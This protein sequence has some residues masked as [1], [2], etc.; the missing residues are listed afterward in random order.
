MSRLVL[1]LSLPA[2]SSTAAP[3]A[4][5]TTPP[6]DAAR[7]WLGQYGC[8]STLTTTPESGGSAEILIEDG[9]LAVTANGDTLNATVLFPLEG[10]TLAEYLV[11]SNLLAAISS[12]NIAQLVIPDPSSP[13]S[14]VYAVQ[15]AKMNP[16]CWTLPGTIE[17]DY[18]NGTLTLDGGALTASLSYEARTTES[19]PACDGGVFS[20]SP[21]SGLI[22]SGKQIVVCTR[23]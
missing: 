6:S 16:D 14:C 15:P 23:Q 3:G 19:W 4:G 9:G 21:D 10:G 1:C 17:V 22:G 7:P 12:S 20:G 13:P 18:V 11:C 2:C 5:G 8:T